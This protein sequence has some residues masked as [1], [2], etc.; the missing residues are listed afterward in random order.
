[1]HFEARIFHPDG[2]KFFD[3]WPFDGFEDRFNPVRLSYN[4]FV[5]QWDS[6]HWFY[7]SRLHC[8]WRIILHYLSFATEICWFSSLMFNTKILWYYLN[9]KA[10][11]NLILSPMRLAKCWYRKKRS[12]FDLTKTPKCRCLIDLRNQNRL[13]RKPEK[14][15][16]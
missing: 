13:K 1:M 11:G 10:S 7:S 16:E 8:A 5:N 4:K 15:R 14:E 3:F 9:I 12:L 6:V 2:W